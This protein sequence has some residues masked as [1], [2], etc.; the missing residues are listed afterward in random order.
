MSKSNEKTNVMRILDKLGASYTAHCYVQSDAVS[1]TEVAAF[2]GQDPNAVFKTLVTAAPS[3]EHYV[4]VVPA[5][6]G[7][8]LRKAAACVGEKKIEMIK[9]K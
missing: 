4:F 7:L 8:D 3:R 5:S 1:G 9:S 2:L 6:R